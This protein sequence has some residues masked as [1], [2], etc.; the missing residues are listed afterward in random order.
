MEKQKIKP[1]L[2]IKVFFTLLEVLVWGIVLFGLSVIIVQWIKPNALDA[3]TFLYANIEY[4]NP[5]V[6]I[7]YNGE[8]Q[9]VNTFVGSGTFQVS[10]MSQVFIYSMRLL[11]VSIAVLYAFT[12]RYLVKIIKSIEINAFLSIDNAKRLFRMALFIG[13]VF[14]LMLTSKVVM[15]KYVTTHIISKDIQTVTLFD[16]GY[17]IPFLAIVGFLFLLSYMFKLGSEIAEENKSF[18]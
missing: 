10:N 18:I 8:I 2:I 5:P 17:N 15:Q 3:N 16:V 4:L 6:A 11:A 14:L 12:L 7:Q 9:K 13:S 1:V